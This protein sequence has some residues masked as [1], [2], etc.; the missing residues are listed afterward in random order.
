M[1]FKIS[2]KSYLFKETSL[3][4]SLIIIEKDNEISLLKERLFNYSL[5]IIIHL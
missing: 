3:Y 1:S 2:F 4:L 5:L